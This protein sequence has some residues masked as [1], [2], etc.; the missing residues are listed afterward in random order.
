MGGAEAI[1]I[2]CSSQTMMGFAGSTHPT[3]WLSSPA[4][5]MRKLFLKDFQI[6][7]N[8]RRL[9]MLARY[10]YFRHVRF[11]SVDAHGSCAA[12]AMRKDISDTRIGQY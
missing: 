6:S 11:I 3:H 1:P 4:D 10:S 5:A 9:R 12:S 7:N 8:G 2:N